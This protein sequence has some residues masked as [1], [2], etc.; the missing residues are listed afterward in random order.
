MKW[1]EPAE[2]KF[3]Q[4]LSRLPI[5]HRNIAE[6]VVMKK[7]EE[8]AKKNH[9]IILCGHYEGVDERIIEEIVDEEISIG[10]FVLTGGELPA[11]VLADC[12]VRMLPG[13]LAS[14]ES[15][16]RESHYASLLEYPQYTR[17]KEWHGMEVPEVLLS[18]HHANIE[19]WRREQSLAR[20]LTRRPEL[21]DTAELSKK[22][23]EMLKK[24]RQKN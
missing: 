8:L 11:L 15:F 19:A 20:T 17:P 9:L 12:I 5:F 4:L 23:L 21:L 14:D 6:Q 3:K 10:D 1:N 22:E 2:K 16:E 24:L 18:G 13:V 7:A